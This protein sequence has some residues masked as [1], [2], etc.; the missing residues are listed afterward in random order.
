[1]DSLPQELIDKIIDNLP[2][3]GFL[4]FSYSLVA[5]RW[6][7]RSQQRAFDAISFSSEDDLNRWWTNIP[8][9]SDG[10]PSYVHFLKT[11]HIT[12]WNDPALF[13]RVFKNF[14]SLAILFLYETRVY[15]GLPGLILRGEFGKRITA[16]YLWSSFGSP[17]TTMSTILSL[18]NLK[19]LWI[20]DY[21]ITLG[22]PLSTHPVTP[23]REPLDSLIF[24]GGTGGVAESLTESRVISRYL[25]LNMDVPGTEQLIMISSK[26]VVGLSLYGV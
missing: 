20:K 10:I 16:L 21:K 5:K 13:A 15:G 6:R 9:D 14:T 19:K 1:M 22:E 4:F 18:P 24:Q 26:T 11:Q 3:P 7:R 12:T 8:Q 23:P 2:Q 17:A 25:S